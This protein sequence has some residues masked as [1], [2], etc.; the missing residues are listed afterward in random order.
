LPQQAYQFAPTATTTAAEESEKIRVRP[1]KVLA[2]EQVF[3]ALEVALALPISRLDD[4][5][6]YNGQ[7]NAMIERLGESA[8]SSPD[9][10]RGGIPQMLMLMNGVVTAEATSLDTSRTLRAVVDAPFLDDAEKIQTLFLA[11]LTRP[12]SEVEARRLKEHVEKRA[13]DGENGKAYAEILWALI[14]SPE[15]MLIR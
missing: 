9:K 6:R 1:L 13:A 14:N 7:R 4:G 15:F 10:F 8:S 2:P 3:D 5:P 12:P 11:T